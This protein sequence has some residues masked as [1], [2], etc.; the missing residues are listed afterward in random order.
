VIVTVVE[1]RVAVA[2]AENETVTVQVG[3]HGLFVKVAVTPVGRVEV[4]KVTAVVAP[5]TKVAVIDDVGLDAPCTTAR[6]PGVGV[7]RLK[8]KAGAATVND[9][10]VVGLIPPPVAVIVT[11]TVP[12]VAVDVAEKETVTVHVGLHGLFVKV[13]VT[14]LGRVDVENVT[15]VVVPAARVAVIED[16]ELVAP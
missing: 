14:P 9:S 3:L 5:L 2:V 4:E 11:V 8:S 10:D 13:A 7:E 12:R 15:G 16:E 6:L 1:P